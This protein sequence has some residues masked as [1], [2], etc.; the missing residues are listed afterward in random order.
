MTCADFY[1][2]FITTEKSCTAIEINQSHSD[3]KIDIV[4][5]LRLLNSTKQIAIRY[6]LD[7]L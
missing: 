5:S 4:L 3:D 2:R 7:W 1:F 6:D